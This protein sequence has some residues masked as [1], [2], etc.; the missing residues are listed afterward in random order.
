[1]KPWLSVPS[2]CWKAAAVQVDEAVAFGAVRMLETH[3]ALEDV[4]VLFGVG[5]RRVGPG[6]AQLLDELGEEQL[7]VGP[8]GTVGGTP[9]CDEGFKVCG[10]QVLLLQPSVA[11]GPGL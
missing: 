1:M 10:H 6:K 4:G 5:R 8:L 9:A 3:L 7:V 2:G 11:L